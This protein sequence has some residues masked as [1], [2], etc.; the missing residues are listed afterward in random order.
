MKFSS[1]IYK[2]LLIFCLSALI[3]TIKSTA[4]TTIE[5]F[6]QNRVKY[7]NFEW[8]YFQ[9]DNFTTYF[10]MGGQ[11]IGRFTVQ[12]AEKVLKDIEDRLE[13]RL[14]SDISLLVY[15]NIMDANQTNIGIGREGYN[16][17]GVTQI[18]DNKVFLYFN[19]NHQNLAAQIRKGIAQVI[20]ENMLFGG[21]VQEVLQNSV[22]LNIP[23]WFSGGL[24]SYVGNE[25]NSKFDDRLRDGVLSG[26]YKRLNRLSGEEAKFAGHAIFQYIAE[27]YGENAISNLLYITRINRNM[28]S[29]FLFVLGKTVNETLEEWYNFQLTRY[30]AD[31]QNRD[32]PEEDLKVNKRKQ[33][34]WHHY[35]ARLHPEG[36]KIAY[37]TNQL[38]RYRIHIL[39]TETNRTRTIYR[40]GHRTKTLLT[41][42]SYPLLSWSPDGKM[43]VFTEERRGDNYLHFYDLEERDRDRRL[44]TNFQKITHID[45]TDNASTLLL[46]AIS[47]GQSNIYTYHIPSGRVRQI[48]N[49]FYDDLQPAFINSNNRNGILFLSN[50][51]SI[52]LEEQRIDTILP[53][54]RLNLFFYDMDKGGN[55]V[56]KITRGGWHNNW[57]PAKMD[58][59]YFSFISEESGIRNLIAGYIDSTFSHIDTTYFFEDSIV[60]NPEYDILSLMDEGLWNPDS[61]RTQ[62]V[63]KDTAYLNPISDYA[64]N[65]LDY[66]NQPASSSTLK[67]FRDE[68]KFHFYIQPTQDIIANADRINMPQNTS[69]RDHLN[70]IEEKKIERARYEKLSRMSEEDTGGIRFPTFYFQSEHY[71]PSDTLLIEVEEDGPDRQTYLYSVDTQQGDRETFQLTRVLPYRVKFTNDYV[72]TQFD[73]SLMINRYQKFAEAD[74]TFNNPNL[75]LMMAIGVSDLFEDYRLIGGFRVPTNFNSSEYFLT[76]ENLKKRLDKKLLYYRRS[77]SK[78]Y[79]AGERIP[80]TDREVTAFNL[81]IEVQF[82]TNYFQYGVSYPFDVIRSLR[83][84]VGFR[85]ERVI[86]KSRDNLSRSLPNY[87]E[88]WILARAEYVHD[89]TMRIG[90]NLRTGTRFKLY[91]EIHKEIEMNRDTILGQVD[92]DV[93][94]FNDA[95]LGV[96]GGDFRHYQRVHRQIIWANRF[97]FGTSYGT[98]KLIYFLGGVD[99]AFL[100]NFD[101]SIPVTDEENFAFQTIATNMRG[102]P[103]NIRNGNSFAVFNSELRVPVFTYLIRNPIRSEFIRNFQLVGFADVGT[104]WVGLNPYDQSNPLFNET[105]G[106]V[107]IQVEVEYFRNPIVM[108]YGLGFRTSIFGY[109]LR[110]D[111]ARGLDSGE[112]K[113]RVWHFSIGKDF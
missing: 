16:T 29:G 3:F 24:V 95:Y 32:F 8:S 73:N 9:S 89:N 106:D 100:P 91:A 38:G 37:V 104:A 4:Q 71:H 63:Y 15:N 50:R 64:W 78:V 112:L 2:S 1:L 48:T 17:G 36:N 83:G 67:V 35:Q 81:P 57:R 94:N 11:D 14:N 22:L 12:Y 56:L 20:M 5:E 10:Y 108:S 43:L 98:R 87:T 66:D 6:G 44:I 72:Q 110:L 31:L 69:Y 27:N 59:T 13:Y 34:K 7:K 84:Y 99:N 23:S 61:V 39:D 58:S 93:P 102:F 30:T 109:F 85:N 51:T 101:N 42:Y 28:E 19:G 80:F 97:A 86:Y 76:Y 41:D 107:P 26:N 33:K 74:P 90:T 18:I 49:D 65:L 25:W 47:A 54:G 88:N 53:T 96:V 111:A 62:R 103:Q 68:G 52:T 92:L 40:G 21:S 60:V 82:I 46:S 105:I 75:S 55:E 45:F 79:G 113:D 70:T 77:D